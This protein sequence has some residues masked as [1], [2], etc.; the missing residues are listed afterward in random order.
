MR[1][2]AV[3][4]G[5]QHARSDARGARDADRGPADGGADLAPGRRAGRL[6]VPA[7]RRG[8]PRRLPRA[9]C[10]PTVPVFPMGVGS[11]LIVRDGG[12][13]GV[14]VRLGRGFNGIRVE[15]GRV[16][17]GAGG[18]RRACRAARRRRRGSTSRSCAP[19]PGSIGGAAR[20]NAGCYGSYTADAFVSARAVTRA[21]E[22]VTLGAGRHGLRLSLDAAAART[23][24]D[25]GDAR[26]TARATP[27]RWRADGGADSRG[28]TPASRRRSA[29]RARPSAIRRASRR[30]GAP[31]TCTTSRPGS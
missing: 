5:G 1:G 17:A 29:R 26:R 28:G 6:A 15:D 10:R 11:N 2:L 31:T 21:G 24:R 8:R 13:A 9:R 14:V 27:R 4:D 25:R 30:P 20:M 12:I 3:A 18:A 23:G 7:G 22:T 19:S 16:V